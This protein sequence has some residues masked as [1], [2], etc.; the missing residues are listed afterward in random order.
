LVGESSLPNFN[1]ALPEREERDLALGDYMDTFSRLEVLM[2]A[3]TLELLQIDEV[4][5][6]PFFA[7]LGTKQMIDVLKAAAKTELAEEGANRVRKLC[8]KLAD[9]NMRRNH[10]VHGKWTMHLT[11]TGEGDNATCEWIRRYDHIDPS[12]GG[13]PHDPKVLGMYTFTIPVLGKTT[14]HA[15]EMVEALSVLIEDIPKLRPPAPPPEES[16]RRWI[17]ARLAPGGGVALRL[18]QYRIP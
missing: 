1:I 16:F 13:D 18:S 14:D 9:R 7:A 6:R 11:P 8:L 4:R 12:F 5:A 2:Q 3:A 15:Q 10:I 17:Q